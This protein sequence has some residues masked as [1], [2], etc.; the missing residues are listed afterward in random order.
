MAAR[1]G[2]K[3]RK[4]AAKKSSTRKTTAKKSTARKTT[5][6]RK[7]AAPKA[8]A[9]GAAKRKGRKRG[10]SLKTWAIKG[11]KGSKYR[12]RMNKG[13]QGLRRYTPLTTAKRPVKTSKA[14]STKSRKYYKANKSKIL[15]AAKKRY[16]ANKAAAGRYAKAYY[17]SNKPNVNYRRSQLRAMRKGKKFNLRDAAK[18]KVGERRRTRRKARK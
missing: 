14:Q 15:Q 9:G 2:S 13:Q 3:T 10:R 16:Q 7:T 5:A 4:T 8:A 12:T 1:G 18:R 17:K 6:K 11:R